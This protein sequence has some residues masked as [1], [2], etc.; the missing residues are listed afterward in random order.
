MSTDL[1]SS[2]ETPARDRLIVAL[3]V[4]AAAHAQKLASQLR[5]ICSWVKVGLELYLAAGNAVVEELAVQGYSVFLDLKFHDIPNTVAGAVR[6]AASLGASLLTVHAA[7][8][9]AMLTAAAEAAANSPNSPCLLAVTVL[10]SMDAKQLDAIGVSASPIGQVLRLA[11]VAHASGIHGLVCSAEEV[12]TLREELGADAKLVTPGI[13]PIGSGS[14]DQKR[15]A[16]PS[17]AIRAGASALVV[18]RP[19]TQAADPARAAQLILDE[20]AAAI[21]AG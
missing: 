10:T 5:G 2:L 12:R 17:E 1:S 21:S 4:P 9:P 15:V 8:G 20:I 13:R 18:G 19:I 7:G 16:T 14:G 11:R 3:D 6:S